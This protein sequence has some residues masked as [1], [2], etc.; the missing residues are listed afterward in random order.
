MFIN[1]TSSSIH[2]QKNISFLD[3]WKDNSPSNE[4][5]DREIFVN[6]VAQS[7][8]TGVLSICSLTDL[9]S[10][11]YFPDNISELI[12]KSC[13]NL[14]NIPTL[15]SSIK[16][17]TISDSPN[18]KIPALPEELESFSIDMSPYTYANDEFPELPN[19]LLSFTAQNGNFLPRFS[20]SLQS[21]CVMDFTEI[22]YVEIPYDL[23]KMEIYRSPL[24][25]LI[26]SIPLDL[27]ELYLG[28]VIIS[29]SFL[30]EDFL[31]DKLEKLHIEC[32]DNITLPKKLP[33]SLNE[34]LLSSIHGKSWEI[35]VDTI[36]KGLNI[37]T[38]L[39]NLSA[40]ILNRDDV[41]FSGSFMGEASSFKLGDVVYGL[42]G[43]RVRINSLVK[44]IYGFTEKDIIIQNTLTNAVWSD[45][46]RSKFNSNH[47]I[48]E[49]LNDSER[50]M[51]FKEFLINHPQYNVTNVR[52]S[53]LSKEDIWMKTSKAGLEFQTKLR[54]RDVIFTL[55]KLVDSIDDIARK[56]G[57]HGD[58]ITAHELRWIYRH[59]N[60][61]N[62]KTHVK[63]FI[64]GKP[65][66]QEKVF[67]LP[68]W[69]NYKPKRLLV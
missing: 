26:E 34:I 3:A 59:R 8:E 17:I 20:T 68:E 66:S 22:P 29:E 64:N 32:C 53:H 67:S 54:K 39:I 15:P 33:K 46:N 16:I 9:T 62:I 42:T 5:L 40:E 11:P 49:R 58:A 18:L 6:E 69:E 37:I 1:H 12:I 28:S 10:I 35:D 14:K 4:V 31:P 27:K 25:P 63:F 51:E 56:N 48:N 23:K 44:S 60:N 41:K 2:S 36:P 24:I 13:D 30:I 52:F 50:G 38:D 55:D 43:E 47:I 19:N 45:R 21:L 65:V 7:I 57:K 61:E